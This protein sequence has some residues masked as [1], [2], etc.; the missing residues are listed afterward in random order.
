MIERP[1]LRTEGSGG[2]KGFSLIEV[3]IACAIAAV[4]CAAVITVELQTDSANR[5]LHNRTIAYR[6]AHQIMEIML[7]DDM[8]LMLLQNGNTFVVN[9]MQGGPTTGTIT[10][11]DLGW[12]GSDRAWKIVLTIPL[13]G[14]R[15]ESISLEAVRARV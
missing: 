8:D 10:M 6:A 4:V 9:E 3:M 7:S 1:E 12:N 14:T 13:P 15:G 11:T 2:E 5:Y